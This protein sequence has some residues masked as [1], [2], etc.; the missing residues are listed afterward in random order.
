M[1][2]AAPRVRLTR[3]DYFKLHGEPEGETRAL[4]L[5]NAD[6]WLL[7]ANAVLEWA[8]ADGVD[9][10]IDQISGNPIASG[11]RPPGANAATANAAAASTH[12][13]CEGGDIQ[14]LAD[15]RFACWLVKQQGALERAGLWLEDPRWT[16]GR[17]NTDPWA[18]LQTRGPRS[19]NRIYVPSA[20]TPTDPEFYSRNG[21]LVPAYLR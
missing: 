14:D 15:R 20:L 13:T 11:R 1:I 19:G 6:R 17:T 5:L 10:G 12:L 21:L 3:A 2:K 9:V 16:G 7:R 18:H 4:M 8:L